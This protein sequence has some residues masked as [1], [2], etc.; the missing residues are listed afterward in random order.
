MR[1]PPGV[2]RR[3]FIADKIRNSEHPVPRLTLRVAP[4]YELVA[5]E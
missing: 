2:A 1:F 3:L 4:E 5:S